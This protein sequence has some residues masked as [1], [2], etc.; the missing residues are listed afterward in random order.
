MGIVSL[1]KGL[2]QQD[3]HHTLNIYTAA[4]TKGENKRTNWINII[5]VQQT[6][7][8]VVIFLLVQFGS[9]LSSTPASA[10]SLW[11]VPKRD[12][13]ISDRSWIDSCRW[14]HFCFCGDKGKKYTF[15]NANTPDKTLTDIY[16][17]SNQHSSFKYRTKQAFFSSWCVPRVEP[18][19]ALSKKSYAVKW[20]SKEN[21][22]DSG[23]Y[24]APLIFLHIILKHNMFLEF[25]KWSIIFISKIQSQVTLLIPGS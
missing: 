24:R 10:V 22:I 4:N 14:W 25:K 18:M 8:D 1:V 23:G 11:V 20:N 15:N 21:F 5:T 6:Q 7:A 9:L 12:A 2:H 17:V 19:A 3:I 13:F 16:G